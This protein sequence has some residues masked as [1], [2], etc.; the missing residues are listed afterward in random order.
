MGTNFTALEPEAQTAQRSALFK[1]AERVLIGC[2]VHFRKSLIRIRDTASLVDPSMVPRFNQLVNV[3]QS[4]TT[5]ELEFDAA[6]ASLCSE[7]PRVEH[8]INWW[9]KGWAQ[10]MAFPAKSRVS[11]E[12]RSNAPKTSNPV[13]HQH[14]LLNHAAGRGHDLISGLMALLKYVEERGA[15]YKAV[16]EGMFWC[17]PNVQGPTY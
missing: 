2:T 5:T 6:A 13:E 8:W 16:V 9:L 11:R 14:S 15:Q 17:R 12:V 3:M 10:S 7:F 4:D 1:D